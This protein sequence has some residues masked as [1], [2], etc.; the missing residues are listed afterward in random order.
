LKHSNISLKQLNIL[1]G[2]ILLLSICINAFTRNSELNI[3]FALRGHFWFL[4]AT[5][6]YGFF[7]S[8]NFRDV[9]KRKLSKFISVHFFLY[10]CYSAYLGNEYVFIKADFAK[11]LFLLA[12]ILLPNFIG[13]I[14]N[15]V[16][17]NCIYLIFIFVLLSYYIYLQSFSGFHLRYSGYTTAYL[18]QLFIPVLFFCLTYNKITKNSNQTLFLILL[19][20]FFYATFLGKSRASF[21]AIIIGLLFL[22]NLN[23]RNDIKLGS[24]FINIF[25]SSINFAMPI[26]LAITLYLGYSNLLDSSNLRIS[27]L[28]WTESGRMRGDNFRILEAA[29]VFQEYIKPNLFFGSGFGSHFIT[30]NGDIETDV[31]LGLFSLLYKF[32]LISVCLFLLLLI[33]LNIKY[34]IHSRSR[35]W[36]LKE[37]VLLLVPSLTIWLFFLIVAKGLFPESLFGLGLTIGLYLKNKALI[38]STLYLQIQKASPKVEAGTASSITAS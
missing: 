19:I 2:Y 10:I 20:V 17:Q 4:L 37:P 30:L 14:K 32:G 28:G 24:S 36:L 35:K 27:E 9:F 25:K 13:Y 15:K 31:H 1:V 5:I 16:F 22:I 29:Y 34:F 33:N 12:G 23:I 18:H 8:S 11:I 26:F 38:K 7:V 6:L 3:G 21:L